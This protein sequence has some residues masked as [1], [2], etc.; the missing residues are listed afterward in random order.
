MRMFSGRYLVRAL[1]ALAGAGL[2]GCS[3]GGSS[4]LPA[5]P[6]SEAPA[7]DGL[8]EAYA[9]FKDQFVSQLG[10]DQRFPIGYGFH[11]GL[12]SERLSVRGQ[13][14]KGQATLIFAE[15]RVVA[16]LEDV[17]PDQEFDLWFVKNVEG[18]GRT[19]MPEA[20][21]QLF[22]VGAFTGVSTFGGR[23]LDTGVGANV[24]FDLDMV[25]VTRAGQDPT[26]SRIAVGS[27]TLFEKR[28]FRERR[29]QGLDPVT[30]TLSNRVETTDPLVR[31]GASLFFGQTFGGNGRTCGTCHPAENN[32]TIDP[33][34]IATRPP[35]D[36]LFVAE[37]DPALALLENPALLR[38]Q[39]LILEN[40]DGFDK[41]PVMRGV[42]HT[43]A[44]ATQQ[45]LD[46]AGL[47]FPAAPPD[48]R[49]GWGGDGSPGRGTLNEFAFGAVMQ[50]FT[51]DLRRRPGTDFRIPTQEE[52]DA[53][54]AFQLFSGRQRLVD[55]RAL[56]FRDARAEQGRTLFLNVDGGAQC[57][58][59]HKDLGATGGD[60]DEPPT[61]EVRSFATGTRVLTPEL[62]ADDG[63]LAPHVFAEST[64]G[65]AS[66]NVPSIIEAAGTAP[67]FHN[68]GAADIEG[69]VSFYASD[70]F[71]RNPIGRD[72]RI[73]LGEAQIESLGAFLRSLSAA[74]KIRQVRK[75]VEFVR[76]NRSS[77]NTLI[78]D[79]A[80]ADAQHAFDLLAP[81]ALYPIAQ[82]SLASVKQTLIA[83]RAQG[84]A[85]RQ[86]LMD[87][88][89][90]QLGRAKA[91]LF[92]ANPKNE[93]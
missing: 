30:G 73:R 59:C 20:G 24:H 7:E 88:A 67:T 93:F 19:V 51:K 5:T 37:F 15:E 92:S 86:A 12:V 49:T 32:L 91:E 60:V 3:D 21:D 41:P 42:P 31:R 76:G 45:G 29:G 61:A 82:D 10:F 87:E 4:Q 58:V 89:L 56:V 36:P 44:L 68:N 8:A 75:R 17:P 11:Y 22:K 78:L 43:F 80:I 13:S 33:A 52:L 63:F 34:F 16:T 54:E 84:D 46:N 64:I 57:A 79:L 70:N 83:A 47:G 26:T 6:E 62:P 39:G 2:L 55:A 53:L 71:R 74:E 90:L 85:S 50:H 9:F 38:S 25:V 35:S 66:F 18:S 23:L 1:A 65:N 69:A 72:F 81:K 14:P 48:R 40:V 77:G 27:R 28:F